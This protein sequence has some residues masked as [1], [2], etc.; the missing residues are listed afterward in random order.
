MTQWYGLALAALL[1]S[2][3][4]T[5]A[6]WVT[7]YAP[8]GSFEEDVNRDEAPDGWV[9]ASFRSPAKTAWDLEVARSGSA[10]V[11]IWDSAH[12]TD[13]AWDANAG[14]WVMR[15]HKA[16]SPGRQ[17]TLVAWAK[18]LGVTGRA[19]A[20]IAWHRNRSWVSEDH[21][22]PVAGT[23]DWTR[24]AVTAT[25]PD[26]ADSASIYLCLTGSKGSVWFDDVSMVEGTEAPSNR[27]PVDL[28]A[29]ADTGFRDEVDGDGK[30]GWTD[31]GDNDA[32][33]ISLGSQVWRGVPFEVIDPA[34]NDGKSAIVLR[35]S[36]R[37]DLPEEVEVQVGQRCDVVYFLHGCAWALTDGVEVARYTATYADGQ[38][39]EIPI[40]TG[41][42]V[43]DWWNPDDTE[44]SAVGW[45]GAN[46]QCSSIG[47]NIFPWRNPRPTSEITSIRLASADDQTTPLIVA[48]TLGDGPA[49]LQ[50]RPLRLEFTDTSDWYPWAFALD[51]PTLE[52]ID[53]SFLLDAPAGKHGF[54]TV[55]PDGHFYFEDGTR[56]RF[57]GTNINSR[58]ACGDR[59]Q[60]ERVAARLARYGINMVRLHSVDSRWA[61]LIDY[62]RGDSRHFNAEAL[63]R[64]DYFV[65]QLKKHGIY[66]YFDLLDYRRF[67]DADGVKQAGDF[68]HGWRNSIKGSS[69][70]DPRMIEL[71]KEYATE[72]LTHR[73]PYTGL[74][75]V[76][77]PA[78]V[79]LEIT[80]ENS[81]FY[82]SNTSLTL[83]TYFDD[84]RGRWNEWL[85]A[86]Y[87]DRDG[88][89][90]AWTNAEGECALLGDEDPAAGTVQMPLQHL[91][92]DLR[93][94]S[95]VG[96]KSPARLNAMTRFLYEVQ[97]AY[98]RTMHDHLRS[99]GVR[100]PITGTNQDFSD[101]SNYAN[102]TC[103]FMS[104]NNYWHHPNL[105]AKPM[106]TFRNESVLRSDIIAEAN[107]VANIASST[108]AGKPM[109]V[110]ELNFP[111]PN[112]Y[113]AECLPFMVAYA[114]LQDWDGILYFAYHPSE[115]R[116]SFFRNQSD[117]VRWGQVPMAALMFLRRDVETAKTYVEIGNS[118]VDVFSTRPRRTSDRY[119][120]YRYLPYIS[121]VRNAYFDEAYEGKAD[122]VV[123]SGHSAHGSYAQ[124]RRAIVFADS[125]YTDEAAT[126]ADRAA[127][128]LATVPKLRATGGT[129]EAPLRFR[130]FM[131]PDRALSAAPDTLLEAASLPGGAV[132]FGTTTDG[133]RCLG[134]I[135][136]RFCV[137]PHV[138]ALQDG[139]PAWPHRLYLAAASH[140]KLPGAGAPEEAGDVFRSD[141]GQLVLDRGKGLFTID[142]P[143]MRGAVGFLGD[144]GAVELGELRVVCRTPFASVTVIALDGK[145]LESSKR[146]LIT[147]VARSENTGQAY[148]R[149]HTRV[150]ELG[151]LP[152][153]AEPVDCDLTLPGR[154]KW[155]AYALGPTGKRRT[156]LS[157]DEGMLN[158]RPA[159]SPWILALRQ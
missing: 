39:V 45:E 77:E 74:R 114:C 101:A 18:P 40:R 122:V 21:S 96:E 150:P 53:L 88:L 89:A 156:E 51:D 147:A 69:C 13:T 55:R 136:K 119:S 4:A 43:V 44:E 5:S 68:Q 139:D 67:M 126:K 94:A 31:Q 93:D 143:A 112:E 158:T 148:Y 25:A 113:R 106:F 149:N 10:S 137:A 24:L 159:E 30:G 141:T 129:G 153:L 62:E 87:E 2:A 81:V 29:A 132:R 140:W 70:Y 66:V 9:P 154:G 57:F 22:E 7:D 8:N 60:S 99:I 124:A 91:Y 125:P 15:E 92:A 82:M 52:E 115:D 157:L 56:A 35:G 11:R 109:I 23:G 27:R 28:R 104:R 59:E 78:L 33:A 107:P 90:A 146:L 80:N 46:P 100:I 75:Y 76:D 63:D 41:R 155:K 20:A 61:T 64:Y 134:F 50:D 118:E 79:V 71:Q 26:N 54:L 131:W 58:E 95:Y 110:P 151:R 111:F 117:P 138:S 84:L 36:S 12:A 6:Q 32:R 37:P 121:K 17:Y 120:P 123:A 98:F 72:L 49:A 86:R 42:E 65:A 116:L 145:R 83:P 97:G 135:N 144:V 128:A 14:R 108:V 85:L 102:A 38:T 3:A 103:D 105:N 16:I 48:M 47:F 34:E 142:A 19:T 133:E 152:V 73:N 1:V 130:G 127:S